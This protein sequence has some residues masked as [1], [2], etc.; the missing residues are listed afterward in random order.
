[1]WQ[2]ENLQLF[3]QAEIVPRHFADGSTAVVWNQPALFCLTKELDRLNPPTEALELQRAMCGS[4]FLVIRICG[5][6]PAVKRP[7]EAS[8]LLGQ[9]HGRL[10]L[11]QRC[12]CAR[13]GLQTIHTQLRRRQHLPAGK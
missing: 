2:T 3:K 8:F 6:L 7:Q 4:S 1:M 10:S 13:N 11:F 9:W 12:T 5:H